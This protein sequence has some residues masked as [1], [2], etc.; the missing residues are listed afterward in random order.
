MIGLAGMNYMRGYTL[1]TSTIRTFE[2]M[3]W[4]RGKGEVKKTI[5]NLIAGHI[6]DNE[7]MTFGSTTGFIDAILDSVN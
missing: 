3:G 5:S 4:A 2:R 7:S 1:G 6:H